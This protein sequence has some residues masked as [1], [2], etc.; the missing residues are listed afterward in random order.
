MCLRK[1]IY[2]FIYRK[3]SIYID[4]VIFLYF[5]VLRFLV[6]CLFRYEFSG[7][8]RCEKFFK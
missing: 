6:G 3:L 2:L 4:K 7:N 8:V 1:C 5:F